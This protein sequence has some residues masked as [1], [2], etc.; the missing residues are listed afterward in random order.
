[1]ACWCGTVGESSNAL[2][3][4][5][6]GIGTHV[7]GMEGWNDVGLGNAGLFKFVADALFRAV[8]LNPHLAIYDVQ[9]NKAVMNPPNVSLPAYRHN[10]IAVVGLVEHS[11]ISDV[12]SGVA[13][14]RQRHESLADNL[15]VMCYFI[16]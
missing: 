1:M 6:A 14:L 5:I 4:G 11:F 8:A 12:Q 2:G 9:M 7:F 10:E 15:P 16:H 3:D 13:P